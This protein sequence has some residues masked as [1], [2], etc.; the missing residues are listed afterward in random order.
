MRTLVA[1]RKKS[2]ARRPRTRAVLARIL[3]PVAVVLILVGA[4]Y[5]AVRASQDPRLALVAVNVTGCDRSAPAD[6]I[7]AAAFSA[8]QNVWL[9]DVGGATARIDALPWV[10]T[11]AIR[12][13]WPNHVAIEIVERVPV[14]RL[15]LPKGGNAEEPA[16][17]EAL[18]DERLRVLAVGR[19]DARDLHLPTLTVNGFD[20]GSVR[21]G[22]DLGSTPVSPALRAL[23]ALQSGGLPVVSMQMDDVTGI[24]A[25]SASGI[26][27]LFGAPEDLQRKIALFL[28]IAKKID[29]PQDV[30]YVDVRSLRAPT[31]L[32]R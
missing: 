31:V 2:G 7:S 25:Q 26:H 20:A 4:G 9:L 28:M 3:G 10:S 23:E 15:T 14:A 22:A 6:V 11:T 29:R 13:T 1:S 12:R 27:V 16:A 8:G 5:A 32:F 30:R 18:L 21:L 17:G 24:A 19:A